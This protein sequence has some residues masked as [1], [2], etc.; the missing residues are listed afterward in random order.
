MHADLFDKILREQLSC[1]W[2]AKFRGFV[3]EGRDRDFKVKEDGMLLFRDRVVVHDN[4][5]LR[6]RIMSEAHATPYSIHPGVE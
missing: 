4:D 5:G 6:E 3:V 2:V 1:P